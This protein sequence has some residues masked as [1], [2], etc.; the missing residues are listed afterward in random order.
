MKFKLLVLS[1]FCALIYFNC[2][3]EIPLSHNFGELSPKNIENQ[4]FKIKI[5]QDTFLKTRGGVI[6]TLCKNTF[7][8]TVGQ[9]IEVLVKE[10]L[11]KKDVFMSGLPTIASD[12]RL[13]E[14]GGMLNITTNPSLQINSEC[15]IQVKVP[16]LKNVSDMQ[17]FEADI[18]NGEAAWRLINSLNSP[19]ISDNLKSG[20]ELFIEN[21]TQCHSINL[22]DPLTGPPLN[23][24]T[25]Y[26]SRDWLIKFTRNSQKMID[27]GDKDAVCSFKRS[28]MLMNTFLKLNDAQINSIYDY[29]EAIRDKDCNCK[30]YQCDYIYKCDSDTSALFLPLTAPQPSQTVYYEFT[31]KNYSWVNIDHFVEGELVEPVILYFNTKD[32]VEACLVFNKSKVVCPMIQN[33]ERYNMMNGVGKEKALLPKGESVKIIAFTKNKNGKRMFLEQNIIIEEKNQYNLVLEEITEVNFK[34]TIKDLDFSESCCHSPKSKTN[35]N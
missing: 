30:T 13:L 35:I 15:P 12:G 14:T 29:I 11:S 25:E 20:K 28:G 9:E 17:L 34:K 23:C 19:K 7:M 16:A 31:I 5:G 21:C 27:E 2:K 18:N 24:V 1:F 8:G 22:K 10:V 32:M 26:R 3:N 33:G 4:I 6:I